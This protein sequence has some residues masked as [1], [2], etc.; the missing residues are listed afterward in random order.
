MKAETKQLD[1]R[2]SETKTELDKKQTEMQKSIVD[3]K[4]RS[5]RDNLVFCGIHEEREDCEKILQEFLRN[6]LKIS[7]DISFERVH[8]TGK[9]DEFSVKPRNIVAKFSFFKD[10]ELVRQRAPRKL[11]GSN[12]WINEQPPPPPHP[13]NRRKETKVIPS[14]QKSEE[15]QEE[16][17]TSGG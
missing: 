10:R 14:S 16:G 12:I 9:P 1:N 15:R 7:Q 17:K 5:M 2:I 11:K 6:K 8:R 4:S 13:R 3:L